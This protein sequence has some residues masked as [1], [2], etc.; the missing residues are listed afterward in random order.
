MAQ[1]GV[2]RSARGTFLCIRRI[3][4]KSNGGSSIESTEREGF[5]PSVR[6]RTLDFKSS[7]FDHSATSPNLPV[8]LAGQLSDFVHFKLYGVNTGY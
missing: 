8:K 1:K 2:S 5:E 4:V 6:F 7:A 3:H